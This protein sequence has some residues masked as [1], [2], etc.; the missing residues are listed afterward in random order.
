VRVQAAVGAFAAVLALS[1]APTSAFA[2]AGPGSSG[3]Q[4]LTIGVGARP[5]ALAEAF[6]GLADDVHALVYNPAGL[7]FLRRQ[8][9][10]LVHDQYAS[11]V[12]HEWG[13]YALPTTWGTFGASAN[14]LYVNAFDAYDN[15]DRPAGQ[16][17]AMDAAYQLSYAVPVTDTLSLGLSGKSVTSRLSNYSAGTVAGDAGLMWRPYTSLHFGA[18]VLNVGPG[19][20]YISETSRLPSTIRGGASWTPFDPNDFE[21]YFTLAADVIKP[22]DESVYA[23]VGLEF[24]Y[25]NLLAIRAGGRTGS[26]ANVGPGYTLGAGVYLHH[27]EREP[28]EICFDYAFVDSGDFAQT[29]RFSV[30]FKFGKPMIDKSRGEFPV[31]LQIYDADAP[32]PRKAAPPSTA[33]PPPPAKN[34]SDS[35][36]NQEMI[37]IKL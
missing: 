6:T 26:N 32:K 25:D 5:A 19:L 28:L 24:W 10:G 33:T 1:G 22:R 13:G 20:T 3:A 14:I 16:T 21:N 31:K 4:F 30:I 11:G 7:A 37:W 9:F 12:Y 15:F 23:A 29:H 17:S 35:S 34:S 18:A 8:E 27:E 2:D 36:D